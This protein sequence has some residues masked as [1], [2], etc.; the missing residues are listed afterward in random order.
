MTPSPYRQPGRST[1]PVRNEPPVRP[2]LVAILSL[3]A[4]VAIVVVLNR[5]SERD[6][7]RNLGGVV[8]HVTIVD[9]MM[10]SHH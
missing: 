5:Q 9:V 1:P 10:N 7:E 2:P 3:I 6:R 4:A 8:C